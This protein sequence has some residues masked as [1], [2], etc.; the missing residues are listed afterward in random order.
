MRSAT[1]G[2]LTP[3][4]AAAANTNQLPAAA[5]AALSPLQGERTW[6]PPKP[7]HRK[8]PSLK[9]PAGFV[10][11]SVEP[12]ADADAVPVE[13]L[14]SP[15]ARAAAAFGVRLN[16]AGPP[17]SSPHAWGGAA[18]PS[19]ASPEHAARS[20]ADY[21]DA[22]EE[23]AQ[24]A[25]ARALA[26]AAASPGAQRGPAPVLAPLPTDDAAASAAALSLAA[27]A[28]AARRH[29]TGN[30]AAA[31]AM[32][33]RL[34]AA[35]G[36]GG[37]RRAAAV[38]AAQRPAR[39]IA[40]HPFAAEAE[41][42]LSVAQGARLELLVGEER[43]GAGWCVVRDGGGATGLVPVGFLAPDP[44]EEPPLLLQRHLAAADARRLRAA[45]AAVGRACSSPCTTSHRS[46][47]E[48]LMERGCRSSVRGLRR[49]APAGASSAT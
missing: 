43:T 16:A 42:E 24:A 32:R 14:P 41:G 4:S 26:A 19:D 28:A 34:Q 36:A 21:H 29:E 49:R 47:G 39:L 48:L 22:V 20:A 27:A 7:G 44:D 9:P 31:E 25:L 30:L 18:P 40:A 3:R 35:F 6:S 11:I 45:I 12:P 46:A 17:A 8:A 33:K 1:T 38:A 10:P 2:N 23:H 5:P 37:G 15:K 13:T